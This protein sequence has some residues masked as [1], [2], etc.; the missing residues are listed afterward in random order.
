[1]LVH[2]PLADDQYFGKQ[3]YKIVLTHLVLDSK[4]H[5][6]HFSRLRKL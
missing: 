2:S 3:L 5:M 4:K 1:M 6:I